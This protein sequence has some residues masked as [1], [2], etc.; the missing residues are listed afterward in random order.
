MC[1]DCPI[2]KQPMRKEFALH[3]D[4]SFC[5]Y[6]LHLWFSQKNMTNFTCLLC[7]EPLYPVELVHLID[8]TPDEAVIVKCDVCDTDNILSE[9]IVC[10]A[11]T[12]TW[13]P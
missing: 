13:R 11:C 5:K 8:K 12:Y 9:E 4:H 2:C 10:K 7:E 3:C 1:S 6:C